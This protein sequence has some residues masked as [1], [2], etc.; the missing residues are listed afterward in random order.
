MKIDLSFE[1]VSLEKLLEPLEDRPGRSAAALLITFLGSVTAGV[2]YGQYRAGAAIAATTALVLLLALGIRSR[3]WE[4]DEATENQLAD[5]IDAFSES[6]KDAAYYEGLSGLLGRS[7]DQFSAGRLGDTA[8]CWE[9][10]N[11][12]L[13]TLLELEAR[14]LEHL[15]IDD[16]S[17]LVGRIEGKNYLI[18]RVAG[19]LKTRVRR[20]DTCPLASDI[21]D[22]LQ[23]L[24][25]HAMHAWVR[26]F[27]QQFIIA[28][29]AET[30]LRKSARGELA[31][32]A[33]MFGLMYERFRL[34]E[35]VSPDDEAYEEGA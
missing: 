1:N 11:T 9:V 15:G 4:R 6:R 10:R 24:G 31:R 8:E 17:L 35:P 30:P 7:F 27:G 2:T 29:V 28:A 22:A 33:T 13:D 14:R 19:P 3:G 12:A 26:C 23:H 5:A 25:P 34:M 16:V 20:D 21:D 32:I 18:R